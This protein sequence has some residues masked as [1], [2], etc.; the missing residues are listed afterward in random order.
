MAT[1]K[2]R[3]RSL[4]KIW[5]GGREMLVRKYIFKQIFKNHIFVALLFVLSFLTSLSYFFV[6][7]SIDGNVDRLEQGKVPAE[8]EIAFGNALASNTTLADIFLLST[9]LLTCFVFGMFF[10]RFFRAEKEK[11]G[12][13]KA[14]GIEDRKLFS[15]FAGFT[16]VWSLLG[17][18]VGAAAGYFL[19]EVLLSAY[20]QSYQITEVCRGIHKSSLFCGIGMPMIAYTVVAFFCFRLVRGKEP[21]VLI[22]GRTTYKKMGLAF[23]VADG[24]VQCI[25]EKKRFPFR[26]A[27]RKPVAVL[28]MAFAILFFQ[29]CMILGQSLNAS[30]RKITESQMQ[31][32]DYEYDSRLFQTAAGEAP[33]D[34]VPYLATEG[35]VRLSHGVRS[36]Q[37]DILQTITGLYETNPFF[38]LMN[39]QGEPLE[40][41]KRGNIYINP[42]LAELYHVRVGEKLTVTVNGRETSFTVGAVV[43]NAKTA[44]VYCDGEE[45][46][47]LLDL[48]QGSY[49]GLWS[50]KP[51]ALDGVTES[52]QE[53]MERLERDAVSN[54][55]SAVINQLTGAL[56]G[57]ILLFLALFLNFQDNQRDMDIL[58]MLG[59]E[60]REIRRLFVDVYWPIVMA[61]F[62][63]L[64]YPGIL[65]A[66]VIQRTLSIAIEDYMPFGVTVGGVLFLLLVMNLLYG[67][68][69]AV[70]SI[71]LDRS[72]R[73]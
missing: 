32:H 4:P 67:G 54:R 53:R 40:L 30:S 44:N 25:P 66:R 51:P 41:P 62:V 5:Y 17:G 64:L 35:Y 2:T 12:C 18:I 73:K 65:L 1:G 57:M 48:T 14:L 68:V 38:P 20:V 47:E 27:L 10:Y 34:A 72:S 23:R 13:L 71:R 37:N 31:G 21:G 22:A 24:L 50:T 39:E 3:L 69:W 26:I 59:Y 52:R 33:A 60:G 8:N 36:A 11:L 45:L 43:S 55:L 19:S 58:K 46:A 63:L 42:G 29:V 49:N 61:F 70:F 7:F 9:T 15:C 28:L 16:M 56:I 6:R